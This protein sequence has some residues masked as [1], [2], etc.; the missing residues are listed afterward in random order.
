MN[1]LRGC[2]GSTTPGSP[3]QWAM[4]GPG[5]PPLLRGDRCPHRRLL[6]VVCFQGWGPPWTLQPLSHPPAEDVQSGV[7]AESMI[8]SCLM[9]SPGHMSLGP[10][11][12]GQISVSNLCGPGATITGARAQPRQGDKGSTA[13]LGK[14]TPSESSRLRFRPRRTDTNL[15]E[16]QVNKVVFVKIKAETDLMKNKDSGSQHSLP[17]QGKWGHD[18]WTRTFTV[19]IKNSLYLI[20]FNM[21]V[22]GWSSREQSYSQQFPEMLIRE[23]SPARHGSTG[24]SSLIL[25]QEKSSVYHGIHR[26]TSTFTSE[27]NACQNFNFT[28]HSYL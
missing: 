11:C 12:G 4:A 6:E 9:L 3:P 17:H 8:P 1:G 16:L 24:L 21:G 25:S 2:S 15:H 7:D 28:Q 20:F 22:E 26:L 27:I 13:S 23:H 19:H 14:E 10:A 18:L 5:T